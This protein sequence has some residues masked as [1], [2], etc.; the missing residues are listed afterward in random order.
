MIVDL[1]NFGAREIDIGYLSEMTG[2]GSHPPDRGPA[3]TPRSPVPEVGEAEL[4][5]QIH[6]HADEV[7]GVVVETAISKD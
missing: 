4:P 3:Q 6:A 5:P 2:P 1:G 7:G